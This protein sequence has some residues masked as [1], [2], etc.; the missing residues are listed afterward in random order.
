M[1]SAARFA[2]LVIVTACAEPPDASDDADASSDDAT[3]SS[4]DAPSSSGSVD[5]GDGF[6]AACSPAESPFLSAD[7]LASLREACN[8][9]VDEAACV[10]QPS[11]EFDGYSVRCGWANVLTIAD[12][13]S[14]TLVS[15]VGRCEATL[16]SECLSPCTAIT[17]ALEIVELCDGPLGPWSAVDDD[18]DDVGGCA[19]NTQP[20]APALCDCAPPTCAVD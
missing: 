5:T 3:S 11:F 10:A 1:R 16:V 15:E 12:A 17:S 18:T 19:P 8:A 9:H 13:T 14:C 20:P 7:C 6:P 4:G 2:T